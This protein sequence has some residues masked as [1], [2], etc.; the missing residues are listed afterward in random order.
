MLK[1]PIDLKFQLLTIRYF[2]YFRHVVVVGDI[3][4]SHRPIDH[5]DPDVERVSSK[6]KLRPNTTKGASCGDFEF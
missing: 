5:C 2:L 1:K 3:N 6:Y 4:V